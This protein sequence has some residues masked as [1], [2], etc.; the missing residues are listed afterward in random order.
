MAIVGGLQLTNVLIGSGKRYVV[1][2]CGEAAIVLSRALS[3]M[4]NEVCAFV[5]TDGYKK[6]DTLAG[7]K[8]YELSD[9]MSN[10][11]DKDGKPLVLNTVKKD[12]KKVEYM[13]Q[14][15]IKDGIKYYHVNATEDVVQFHSFFYRD[16][17]ISKRADITGDYLKAKGHTFINPFTSENIS[18]VLS[19]FVE[20]CDLILPELYGDLSM[21]F[22]GP[23]EYENVKLQKEDVVIDCGSNIGLFASIAAKKSRK[24]YAFEPIEKACRYI[25]EIKKFNPNIV[26][27]R[28]ACG[29]E[30]GTVVFSASSDIAV[31]KILDKDDAGGIQV[32][33]TDLDSFVKE[34]KIEKVDFIKAD[35]EGAER[36]MLIGA[37]WILKTF[38]PKLSICEYHYPDD[39]EILEKLVLEANPNY[40]IEHEYMKMNAYVP[41]RLA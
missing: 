10:H 25:D 1:Y 11:F 29:S 16:Y 31:N 40:I 22:E 6:T 20:C 14:K 34:N 2:G 15:Y 39:P 4:E 18:Y 5:C 33:I 30:K 13:F 36:D 26:L 41:N 17:F 12:E 24:V 32:P 23:Y 38:E 21:V 37:S 28:Q 7:I 3:L 19:F 8:V 27:C 35:I 9:Y